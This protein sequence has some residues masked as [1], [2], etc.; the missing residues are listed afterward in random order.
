MICRSRNPLNPLSR[1]FKCSAASIY[2]LTTMNCAR[3]RTLLPAWAWSCAGSDNVRRLKVCN[4]VGSNRNEDVAGCSRNV[5]AQA[6]GALATMLPL[7]S[8]RISWPVPANGKRSRQSHL[9][10]NYDYSNAKRRARVKS[11]L[12]KMFFFFICRR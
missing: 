3:C 11:T 9:H 5:Q 6:A 12:I 7:A 2:H 1:A 4:I 8:A 10:N